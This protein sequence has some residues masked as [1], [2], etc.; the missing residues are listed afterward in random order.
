MELSEIGSSYARGTTFIFA[1]RVLMYVFNFIGSFFLA[2]LLA[3]KYGSSEPLGWLLVLSFIPQLTLL[4]HDLGIRYGLLNRASRLAKEKKFEEVSEYM[5]SSIAITLPLYLAY[6]IITFFLGNW[7]AINLYSKPEIIPYI[8]LI[9]V[10]VLT[11]YLNGVAYNAAL[12]LDKTWIISLMLILQSMIQASAPLSL[13]LGY[14]IYGIVLTIYVLAPLFSSIPG[15][16]VFLKH[17]K[18]RRIDTN[19]IKDMIKFG[20]P[21]AASNYTNIPNARIYEILISRYASSIALGNFSIAARFTP[22]I[23]IFTYPIY[24]I[25][26]PNYSKLNNNSDMQTALNFTI[27]ILAYFIAPISIFLMFF[28]E[29]AI[30]A[31][32]GPFYKDGW[33]YLSLLALGWL[34]YCFGGSAISTLIATQGYTKFVFKLTVVYVLINLIL[35]VILIPLFSIIGALITGLISGWP[36]YFMSLKFIKEKMNIKIYFSSIFKIIL[37]SIISILPSYIFWILITRI[38]SLSIITFYSILA[39]CI[40][41]SL[42]LYI[43]FTKRIEILRISEVEFIEETLKN[44]PILGNFITFV[45]SLYKRI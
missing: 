30:I 38:I 20:F 18:T 1:G 35:N 32:F 22:F 21:L 10:Y 6:S 33:I 34:T 5:Y 36:S 37:A 43:L 12:I 17:F 14:D 26:F 29:Q 40:L 31:I 44:L 19:K 23:D 28:S 15:L 16:I 24:S 42:S 39:F 7:L 2:R 8:P 11:S 25:M 27:K 4:L 9:S 3:L 13:I 45:I 41:I